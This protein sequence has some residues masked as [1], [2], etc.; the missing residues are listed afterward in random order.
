MWLF[1]FPCYPH[2]FSLNALHSFLLG[3]HFHFCYFH[4]IDDTYFL[5]QEIDRTRSVEM[6]QRRQQQQ[7]QLLMRRLTLLRMAG[8]MRTTMRMMMREIWIT[9]T[10]TR[11]WRL[12]CSDHFN[13][14]LLICIIFE[15]NSE[16]AYRRGVFYW[17]S[18]Y[19]S[20]SPT[21][22][23]LFIDMFYALL[24]ILCILCVSC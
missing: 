21:A 13:D 15:T 5:L 23:I 2:L 3:C 9:T 8:I 4:Y 19:T 7:L 18:T 12:T 20:T 24:K 1:T 17:Q 16:L 10:W 11:T 14:Q 6:Q 22:A